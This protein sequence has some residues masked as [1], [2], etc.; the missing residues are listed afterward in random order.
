MITGFQAGVMGVY[1]G[2]WTPANITTALW[3]DAAD[4]STI[5]IATG[6]SQWADKSG[7]ARHAT[8]GTGS[9]QPTVASA[10]LNSKDTIAF[11]R[12]SSQS[13]IC[14]D[15]SK[16]VA[17]DGYMSVFAVTKTTNVALGEQ[18]LHYLGNYTQYDPNYFWVG[19]SIKLSKLRLG[20][21][22]G[23][24]RSIENTTT[25]SNDGWFI[26]S[27]IFKE[28]TNTNRVR[29]NGANEATSTYASVSGISS[30]ARLR[31]GTVQS[32]LD[33][34]LSG[35]I[36]EMVFVVGTPLDSDTE[37]KVE[38]YLAHKWGLTANLPSDHPYKSA[39]PTV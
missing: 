2:L 6:V 26:A 5:T 27:S 28:A 21:Y 15:F 12:A 35:N 39:A 4:S 37:K 30:S 18:I 8:Q 23:I 33:G 36:A 7:N 17:N 13:F 38:G 11:A 16:T 1:G 31:I 3:L 22:N 20:N 25:L 24:E 19:N 34:L 29:V 32:D 10:S 9:K 14:E